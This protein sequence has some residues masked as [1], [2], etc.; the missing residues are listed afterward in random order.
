MKQTVLTLLAAI[1]FAVAV[2]AQADKT[3]GARVDDNTI[4]ASVKA[5]LVGAK[6]VPST[7]INVETYNG[8]VL[9]SGFQAIGVP[10]VAFFFAAVTKGSVSLPLDLQIDSALGGVMQGIIVLLFVLAQGVRA[11][12]A[13]R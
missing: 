4:N 9:L 12:F 7:D 13:R 1:V 11:R 3:A 8:V 10:F 6:G 5:E 2:P